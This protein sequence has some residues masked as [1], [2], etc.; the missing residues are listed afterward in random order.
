MKLSAG[1]RRKAGGPGLARHRFNPKGES[2]ERRQLLAS[3]I[4][5]NPTGNGNPADTYAVGSFN[6][7]VGNSLAVGALPLSVGETYQLDYQSTLAN[8]IDPNSNSFVPPGLNSTY[9][10]TAVASVTEI[11]TSLNPDGTVATFALAPTQSPNSFFEI[12]YNPALVANDLAGTGFNVGTL[13][14]AASPDPT[15]ANSGN[16][17]LAL[18]GGSPIIEPFDLFNPGNYPGI[19]TVTGA[20]S[21]ALDGDVSSLDPAFFETNVG[22]LSFDT[23]NVTP[24]LE[25]DPSMLFVGSPG[26]GPPSIIPDIG[27][28]NGVNGTDFQFQADANTSFTTAP[29]LA[30]TPNP[31]SVTLGTAPVVLSDSAVLSE[32]SVPTGTITFTLLAPGGATVDTETVT[33]DGNGT[34]T[35]PTGYTLPTTGTVTGMYQWD[36]SYSGDTNNLPASDVGAT[37]EQVQVSPA[38]PAI[39]T[40]PDPTS[41]TL[42][43][44]TVTLLDSAVLSGGYFPTGTITFTLVAPGGATVDTETATVNGDG[45]YTTPTGYT[46]PTTGT[47][48]GTYQWNASYTSGDGNNNNASDVGATDEQ[49]PV[50]AASPAIATTPNPTSATLGTTT[51]TLLDSA[52]LSGGYFPTGTITFTLVAPGGGTVDTETV[53][54]DGN[55]T[56]TTPTGYTLPTMGTVT[57]TYQWNASY[58][59]GDGN[60]NNAS[61]VGATD[62][63]VPVSAASPAIATTPNP[64]SATLG[65]T[66]VTLLD[67]AVLSGGYFPIG[68]ITFTLVAP[69][70]G[71]VD[72]ETVTVDG[73]GTYT[74]PAGYT[75][76][77]TG[78]VTGTYQWNA[79]Y[80]SGDDNNNSA[81]DVG[82]TDEQ[83]PVSPASPAIATTPNPTS[84]TLGTTPV[85]LFDS[86]VL[87][88]GYFPIGTITFTLVAPGGGTV[89]T[90]TVT[91]DGNG[92]YTTPAGY[93]L[94]TTG[95]LTGTYQWNASYT[96][97]DGN[98]NGASDLNASDEQVPVSP[99]SPASPTIATTPDPTSA[100][101]GTTTV[102][103]FDSAVLS[104]GNS[105]TGT[106]TF[107]LVAPGGATVDTETVTVDGNGTYTTPTGYT[108]TPGT[109]TATGTYQWNA[110]YTSGNGNNASASDVNSSK[111]QVKVCPTVVN[112]ERF[113]VHEQPM[114]IVVTFSGQV[115]SEQAENINNY[116]FYR[117][118]PD[119]RFNVPVRVTSAAYDPATN[120]V[121]LSFAHSYNLHHFAEITVTNP[122]PGC[123]S[124]SGILNRKYA[125]GDIDD[126]GKI[127]VLPKTNIPGVLNPLV[128]PKVFTSANRHLVFRLSKKP[129]SG[130]FYNGNID[131][132]RSALR[133]HFSAVNREG[134][135]R[136]LIRIVARSG[137]GTNVGG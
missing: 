132:A 73:N 56:Y 136:R 33:V 43:T 19:L 24:F 68:T 6:W 67:S 100:T 118:G 78:T 121:T 95:A 35:T 124:F 101:L 85:T 30:T 125:L 8:L 11:V 109:A 122:C 120:S 110:T 37:D 47:V 123:P 119:G 116:H 39:A 79:S 27:T 32:G 115:N 83:V 135:L 105:P 57:G 45:T 89:D 131:L 127:I 98:N 51:V 87:S 3:P 2:L 137:S 42:G 86:A 104:G 113:G 18:N 129:Q 17:A 80:T 46:L 14:L 66:T 107:S 91:V 112:V 58:T 10:I 22:Q 128:M 20:G 12:Y 50:S 26:G 99:A 81:S 63:Q 90:E 49:A 31:T 34:Y 133:R 108:L 70:G 74:T 93:T 21:S 41:A 82:A 9:Q 88:G 126:H 71:T 48:T 97:G 69:G 15:L 92:T 60:N 38:S 23:S 61:D 59:S 44:T 77:T 117:R 134:R 96:T 114:H 76:P 54:V 72:T 40:T 16:F 84:A 53:T 1:R 13:I 55:G 52:V 64:T 29:T 4:Q 7:A 5:F 36:A 106:I 65:T 25:T 102:T 62:E 111:E 130:A 28:I 75:L 94:P 103:L